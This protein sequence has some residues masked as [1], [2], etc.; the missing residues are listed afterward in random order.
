MQ[1]MQTH[2][3]KY[4]LSC[5]SRAGEA[6]F[7]TKYTYSRVNWY[8]NCGAGKYILY[9]GY[10][11]MRCESKFIKNTLCRFSVKIRLQWRW[12]LSPRFPSHWIQILSYGHVWVQPTQQIAQHTVQLILHAKQKTLHCTFCI[13]SIQLEHFTV[14]SSGI[15]VTH[16][17]LCASASE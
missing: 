14:G 3:K 4:T 7:Q 16:M 10:L 13:S 6:D 9:V 17:R 1:K 11:I 15:N 2:F 5:W 8:P 12:K